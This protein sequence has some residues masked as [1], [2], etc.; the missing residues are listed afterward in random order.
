M[1]K[2]IFLA[3]GM[4]GL[5]KEEMNRWRIFIK[6]NLAQRSVN[7]I[8]PC[9]HVPYFLSEAA[10]RESMIWELHMLRRSDV[11]VCDMSHPNSIGTTWELAVATEHSIPIVGVYTGDKSEAHP[12]WKIS[13]MHICDNLDDLLEYLRLHFL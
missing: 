11:V 4:T 2:Q 3:G 9:E 13:V 5:S 8:N 1:S 7:C 6:E 12:W 10:E